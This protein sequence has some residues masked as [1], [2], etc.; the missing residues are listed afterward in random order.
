MSAMIL[1]IDDNAINLKLIRV[2]LEAAGHAVLTAEDSESALVVLATRRPDVILT[3]LQLPGLDG[4]ELTM[5]VKADPDL[6]GIPVVAVTSYAMK[7]DAERAH[8]AGCDGYVTKPIDGDAL[9]ALVA[10]LLDRTA[11]YA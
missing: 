8:H 7:G 9:C 5:R 10:E 11:D 6:A 1:V 4:Y 2:T 3:D